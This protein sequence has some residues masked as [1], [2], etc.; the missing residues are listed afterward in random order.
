MPETEKER[1]GQGAPQINPLSGSSVSDMWADRLKQAQRDPSTYG[2]PYLPSWP[3]ALLAQLDTTR[4]AAAAKHEQEAADWRRQEMERD[5]KAVQEREE[6]RARRVAAA[7]T[8][9]RSHSVRVARKRRELP[10][11]FT[12][13][14]RTGIHE[15][16]NQRRE[17]ESSIHGKLMKLAD[18][19]AMPA[20]DPLIKGVLDL[21]SESWLI[22]QSGGFKSFVAVDWACHVASGAEL[23]RGHKV[24]P[25]EV[26]YVV[27]EGVRGFAKRVRA[28]KA[29]YGMSPDRLQILSTP[30]QARGETPDKLSVDWDVLTDMVRSM[31]PVLIVLDTQAR[32]TLGMEENSSKE[33]GLW[34]KAVSKLREAS[35]GCVL[36]VHHTGRNGG[37]ARGSSAIDAAQDMEW[38]VERK[39]HEL[40]AVLKCDKSKDGDDRTRFRFSMDVVELSRDEDG[41]AITS[42]V[43]GEALDAFE[44]GQGGISVLE[45]IVAEGESLSSQEW[46]LRTMRAITE[47]GQGLP[48]ATIRS[49]VNEARKLA[50]QEPLKD[51][52]LR[53]A[54][55][56]LVDDGQMERNGA[57]FRMAS[58]E[59]DPLAEFADVA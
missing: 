38:K 11:Q 5:A 6:E 25:G 59:D 19:E 57:Q 15:A 29:R 40:A 36:V 47:D 28:W 8:A 9:Q 50:G 37:D 58:Q 22:G 33:M 14:A 4:K 1:P 18:L 42:L 17:A 32:M 39:A 10:D 21:D 23:W 49:N 30:V 51:G 46:V 35:G 2:G 7:E 3:P 16:V 41:Q 56:R 55:K 34:V 27:G 43:L 48:V 54:L 45:T 24:T 31:K 52:T 44:G 12:D 20:A 13:V 26:L 53:S